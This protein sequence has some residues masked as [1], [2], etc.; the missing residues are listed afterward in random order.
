ME[1]VD[2]VEP[3]KQID[4]HGRAAHD[5]VTRDADVLEQLFGDAPTD[6]IVSVRAA[7]ANEET[8]FLATRDGPGNSIAS[9]QLT[10]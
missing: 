4:R 6:L 5:N 7:D 2:T 1:A 10:R 8:R 3:I 9:R